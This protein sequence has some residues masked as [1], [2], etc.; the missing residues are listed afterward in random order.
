LVWQKRSSNLFWVQE[1][2]SHVPTSREEVYNS[3]Y[4]LSKSE[5]NMQESVITLRRFYYRLTLTYAYEKSHSIGFSPSKQE[6]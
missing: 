1:S 2:S 5:P 4:L 3:D 6:R